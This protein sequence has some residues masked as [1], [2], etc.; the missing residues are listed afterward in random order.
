MKVRAKDDIIDLWRLRFASRG[1]DE[2][3]P[4]ATPIC[5]PL[6]EDA[7][8]KQCSFCRTLKPFSEFNRCSSRSDGKQAYCRDCCKIKKSEW[9]SENSEREKMAAKDWYAKNRD[10]SLETSRIYQQKNR[11]SIREYERQYK[12]KRREDPRYRM[13]RRVR[14]RLWFGLKR[15]GKGKRARSFDIVGCSQ[16]YFIK[17]IESQFSEGMSWENY[18]K[19]HIDHIKP[20]ATAKS[21]NEA[22]KL[23]HYTNLQPLWAKE[24]LRKGAKIGH[25]QD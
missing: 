6:F 18:G 1:R 21:E 9:Y 15:L 8:E 2:R 3:L 11:D 4:A 25:S 13:I 14:H 20:L 24:N 12:R 22:T 7:M 16:N 23:C 10:R 5:S 17:H 19:W